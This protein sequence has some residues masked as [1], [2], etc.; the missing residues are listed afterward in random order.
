M[1][2]LA[3]EVRR[4]L[5]FG[6]DYPHLEQGK[7]LF[8]LIPERVLLRLKRVHLIIIHCFAVNSHQLVQHILP[9]LL[10]KEVLV[11]YP[12]N[13]RTA[14]SEHHE[15][16]VYELSE[17]VEIIRR[18]NLYAGRHN[19][20]VPISRDDLHAPIDMGKQLNA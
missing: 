17:L 15:V 16:T 18:I 9:C 3:H 4:A 13:C 20:L 8:H 10:S 14:P 7:T 1:I 6:W 12:H 11:P 5:L 19:I 2:V